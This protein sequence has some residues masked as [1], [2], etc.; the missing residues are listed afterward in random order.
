MGRL[1][2]YIAATTYLRRG[3]Q[4][5]KLRGQDVLK[6]LCAEWEKSNSFF[7]HSNKV[8]MILIWGHQDVKLALSP[9][10]RNKMMQ[11]FY[12]IASSVKWDVGLLSST[13]L[14][15]SFQLICQWL[16]W[17]WLYY[18]SKPIKLLSWYPH[19][20]QRWNGYRTSSHISSSTVSLYFAFLTLIWRF[21]LV[22]MLK[23]H[24]GGSQWS[25]SEWSPL[26][27]FYIMMNHR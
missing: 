4:D 2:V 9:S 24:C 20:V 21:W 18:L 1:I 16:L 12:K 27:T 8:T 11:A 25:T 6:R 19:C 5:V 14:N 17:K 3:R 7:V 26:Y 23:V 22:K 10:R 15:L 13:F